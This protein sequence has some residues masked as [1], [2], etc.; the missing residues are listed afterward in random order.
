MAGSG[1]A[2]TR[3]PPHCTSR[4]FET[5]GDAQLT[6][7]ATLDHEAPEV[8]ARWRSGTAVCTASQAAA[9]ASSGT[10]ETAEGGEG[11]AALA[12][13][14]HLA[15]RRLA[16]EPRGGREEDAERDLR[17][18][19]GGRV[20]NV[21]DGRARVRADQVGV[22]RAHGPGKRASGLEVRLGCLGHRSA[23]LASLLGRC[24]PASAR[25]Q[26]LTC[27]RGRRIWRRNQTPWLTPTMAMRRMSDASGS[28][29][30]V[31]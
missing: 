1:R 8:S 28:A 9:N 31:A 23:D 4:R 13:E 27:R 22:G 2:R 3:R 26:R 14:R 10:E 11:G 20:G 19:R 24:P 7:L 17:L 6:S 30:L 25:R 5:G 15:E 21:R 18:E 16:C 12:A 29:S